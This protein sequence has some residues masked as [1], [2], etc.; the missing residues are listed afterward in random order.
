MPNARNSKR[1]K[2][3]SAES[4][5]LNV[6]N[7]SAD[8]FKE[9]VSPQE[10]TITVP[11]QLLRPLVVKVTGKATGNVYTFN[12]AG[13]ILFVDEKDVESIMAKN[14]KINQSC[15]GSYS[16]PYFKQL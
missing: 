3:V 9:F 14:N 13:S 4:S 2:P 8:E 1:I 12:G 15:C 5:D 16:S 7:G 10:A 11:I 6:F